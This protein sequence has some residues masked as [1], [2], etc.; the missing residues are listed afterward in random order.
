MTVNTLC[1]D[2]AWALKTT[3]S[4]SEWVF[5]RQHC[6]DECQI[7]SEW[8]LILSPSLGP[9]EVER[10]LSFETERS[11][12]MAIGHQNS[13]SLRCPPESSPTPIPQRVTAAHLSRLRALY[14]A[15]LSTCP[16]NALSLLF[17]PFAYSRAGLLCHVLVQVCDRKFRLLR[18]GVRLVVAV[19]EVLNRVEVM[20]EGIEHGACN[21]GRSAFT[22]H[23][24]RRRTVA[25]EAGRVLEVDKSV[26]EPSCDQRY[27]C[28]VIFSTARVAGV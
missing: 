20:E 8:V 16:A 14:R 6:H 4:I 17:N 21:L 11:C 5:E 22:S 15:K 25:V 1:S 18:L 27:A 28:Y 3:C 9:F 19:G 13:C 23:N 10:R 24:V 2:T 26:S 7:A 12:S